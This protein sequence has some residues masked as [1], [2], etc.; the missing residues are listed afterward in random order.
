VNEKRKKKSNEKSFLFIDLGFFFQWISTCVICVYRSDED[1]KK[2]KKK[3][4]H[5][6][7]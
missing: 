3:L 5:L 4:Q 2:G 7:L 6:S 1:K